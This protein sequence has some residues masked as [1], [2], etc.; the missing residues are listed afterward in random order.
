MHALPPTTQAT[1]VVAHPCTKLVLT[2]TQGMIIL[3]SL[4]VEIVDERKFV[5]FKILQRIVGTMFELHNMQP[6]FLHSGLQD[7][8]TFLVNVLTQ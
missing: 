3:G 6:W 1:T 8:P 5:G 4:Q 2:C 7:V